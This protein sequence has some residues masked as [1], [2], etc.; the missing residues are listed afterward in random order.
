MATLDRRYAVG[1]LSRRRVTPAQR[2]AEDAEAVARTCRAV[3]E[4]FR[5][6]G[7][8]IAFGN[9]CTATDAQHVSV[10]FVHPVIVGKRSLPAITLSADGA[11]VTGVANREGFEEIFAHQLRLFAE[12]EDIALGISSSGGCTNVLRGLQAGH[13]RGL[14]TVGMVGGDGGV[15]ARCPEVDHVLAAAS[16]DPRVVKELHVTTYHILW[17]LVHVFF[18]Q[19]GILTPEPVR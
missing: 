14:L 17:E 9:G 8:L 16:D 6:G 4:R 2:I 13:E 3:A 5:R 12:P 10:E 1:E 18:E 15:I 7:K 19:P 11:A